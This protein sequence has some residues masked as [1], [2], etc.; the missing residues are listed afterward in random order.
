MTGRFV[1]RPEKFDGMRDAGILDYEDFDMYMQDNWA[2]EY[3]DDGFAADLL[4][5]SAEQA[6]VIESPEGVSAY[7]VFIPGRIE[8]DGPAYQYN[9]YLSIPEGGS[10]KVST[11]QYEYPDFCLGDA[12]GRAAVEGMLQDAVIAMNAVLDNV[13]AF[14][15]SRRA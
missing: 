11:P 9:L 6:G 13:D 3:D 2:F 4:F 7:F 5:Q 1:Y 15:A 14:V 10:V 12:K 8:G